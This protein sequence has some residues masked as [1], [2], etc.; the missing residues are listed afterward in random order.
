MLLVRVNLEET[1]GNSGQLTL[2][3]LQNSRQVYLLGPQ[4]LTDWK[5]CGE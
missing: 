4:E 3:S 5:T 2:I 1:S